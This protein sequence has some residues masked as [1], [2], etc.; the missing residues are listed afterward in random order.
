MVL[1]KTQSSG[2]DRHASDKLGSKVTD[3]LKGQSTINSARVTSREGVPEEAVFQAGLE[4][5]QELPPQLG[6]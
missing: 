1:R 2:G 4:R 6:E 3:A 5:T